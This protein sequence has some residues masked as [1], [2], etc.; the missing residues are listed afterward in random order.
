MD[1]HLVYVVRFE[2]D[3]IIMALCRIFH[4]IKQLSILQEYNINCI[5]FRWTFGLH[6]NED[7]LT[8]LESG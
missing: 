7:F 4:V 1:H 2:P 8:I 3:Q 6:T 5:L